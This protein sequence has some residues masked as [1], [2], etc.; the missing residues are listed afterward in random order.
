MIR[1]SRGF[2]L[3]EVVVA[4]AMLAL[5]LSFSTY[6]TN[7][8]GSSYNLN[9]RLS[10][11]HDVAGIV[12]EELLSTFESDAQL[13]DGAHTQVFNDEGKKVAAPGVFTATWTVRTNFPI[14]KIIEISLQVSWDDN[15]HTRSV[16]Y[17]TYRSS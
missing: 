3:M 11:A 10:K 13:T 17:L 8:I 16:R 9:R 5:A 15:G 14:T 12:L 1:N 7:M 2:T 6:S 4:M